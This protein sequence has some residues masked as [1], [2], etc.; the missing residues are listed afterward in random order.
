[1]RRGNGGAW[2]PSRAQ[3]SSA[4]RASQMMKGRRV[5][6]Y[7]L[8]GIG[9]ES[10]ERRAQSG[11]IKILFRKGHRSRV[12]PLTK[13]WILVISQFA[14][15]REKPRGRYPGCCAARRRSRWSRNLRRDREYQPLQGEPQKERSGQEGLTWS[16]M[17]PSFGFDLFRGFV[18]KTVAQ[19]RAFEFPR[20]ANGCGQQWVFFDGSI[21]ARRRSGWVAKGPFRRNVEML[22]AEMQRYITAGWRRRRT[23]LSFARESVF[24]ASSARGS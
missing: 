23:R 12:C 14:R 15:C 11:Q 5:K 8:K 18:W 16:Q 9:G 19:A 20:L 24:N 2:R 22:K 10:K 6:G 3:L 13:P 17:W 1:M 7:S 21:F 4:W